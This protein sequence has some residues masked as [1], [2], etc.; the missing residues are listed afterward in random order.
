MKKIVMV[1]LFIIMLIMA[2]CAKQLD[3]HRVSLENVEVIHIQAGSTKV[4]LKSV[5][6]K[7]VEVAFDDKLGIAINS[8]VSVEKGDKEIQIEV[9]NMLFGIGRKPTLQVHIP[10]EY[11]GEIIVNSSS[12]NITATQ[13][14][15]EN[16]RLDTKS[17]NVSIEFAE[18]QSNVFITTTS[19][20][21]KLNLNT[22][23]PD[24]RFHSKT[25]S[26]RQTV[27]LPIK[28]DQNQSKNEISG[29]LGTG[30]YE[31]EIKT[32]SGDISVQ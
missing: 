31:I 27:T 17:G 13:L 32:T 22:E 15:S 24:L 23:E 5:E 14:N 25:G 12:G 4:E 7:F 6:T 20:N 8:G 10:S 30:A 9:N 2:G 1:Q 18:F 3:G 29:R 16:I 11:T 21:V 26:G 28:T 19:G